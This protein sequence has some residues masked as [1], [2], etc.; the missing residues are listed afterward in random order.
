MVMALEH[1]ARKG[2]D[3]LH[4]LETSRRVFYASDS[5]ANTRITGGTSFSN[6]APVLL[7][8][9]PSGTTAIP[10]LISLAET[11]DT[12]PT[13]N[14]DYL[15]VKDNADRYTSGGTAETV[16]N[17]FDATAANLSTLYSNSGSAIVA[18][19]AYGIRVYGSEEAGGVAGEGGLNEVV[20]TPA[21]GLEY[22]E[23]P[24]AFIVYI[25]STVGAEFYWSVKWAE[26]PTNP[27]A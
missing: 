24:G 3:V 13:S 22:I 23:G 25:F 11:S 16:Y 6:T 19:D 9:V 5:A 4:Y 10:L 21:Q 2:G 12:A 18:T 1:I 26:I 8:D 7:L 14:I 15:M 27:R 17:D 20:W